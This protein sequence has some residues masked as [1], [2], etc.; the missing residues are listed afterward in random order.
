[1]LAMYPT[2]D[3]GTLMWI[4]D[5]TGNG[6][7][8]YIAV[9]DRT[10]GEFALKFQVPSSGPV[11]GVSNARIGGANAT[12]GTTGGNIILEG[13]AGANNGN[14]GN[15][16]IQGGAPNGSGAYGS[17]QIGTASETPQHLLNTATATHASGVGTITNLPSGYSGNPTGYI[18]ITINGNTHVIPYW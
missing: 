13:G 1:M 4:G 3:F 17:V 14:G 5:T 7:S 12:V 6:E 8:I 16:I 2:V 18:Q 11:D 9:R 10:S 15:A